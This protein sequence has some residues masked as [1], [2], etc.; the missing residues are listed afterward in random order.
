M[1]RYR[2]F[3]IDFPLPIDLL[4]KRIKE[5]IFYESSQSGFIINKTREDIIS[6]KYITKEN[7]KDIITDPFGKNSS[8]ERIIYNQIDFCIFKDISLLE[9][10]NPPRSINNFA[11][12]LLEILDFKLT[13]SQINIDLISWYYNFLSAENINAEIS[14]IFANNI[15]LSDKTKAKMIVSSTDHVFDEYKKFITN[16]PHTIDKIKINLPRKYNGNIT[17]SKR[18]VA[19]FDIE[20]FNSDVLH[21]LR[22]SLSQSQ[23]SK[24]YK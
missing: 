17:L 21:A 12:K 19:Y 16:K 18:A 6:G 13:L 10:K 9:I 8:Y 4:Y 15:L 22:K 1:E 3:F 14:S 23:T 24:N 5:Y 20:N 11:N 7:I 2:W